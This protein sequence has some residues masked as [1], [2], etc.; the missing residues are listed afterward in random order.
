M[1]KAKTLF[2]TPKSLVADCKEPA[3]KL[4]IVANGSLDLFIYSC[5]HD[6]ASTDVSEKPEPEGVG[7]SDWLVFANVS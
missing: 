1:F 4:M 5:C 3:D 7:M 2:F 6:P